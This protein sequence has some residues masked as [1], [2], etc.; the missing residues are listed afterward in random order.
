[1]SAQVALPSSSRGSGLGA[2]KDTNVSE[3]K[4]GKAPAIDPDASE[5][6]HVSEKKK[7]KAPAVD[8]DD[9][10]VELVVRSDD[11][12]HPQFQDE[13]EDSSETS[14]SDDSLADPNEDATLRQTKKKEKRRE[15]D[16]LYQDPVKKAEHRAATK[17]RR[18]QRDQ[19]D[20]AELLN[21][22]IKGY[23]EARKTKVPPP[24][25]PEKI[26]KI[27]RGL[28]PTVKSWWRE[29]DS[30]NMSVA[31]QTQFRQAERKVD[32]YINS[33]MK[34]PEQKAAYE[35]Y[36]ARWPKKE[37]SEK[38][39]LRQQNPQASEETIKNKLLHAEAKF[40][41]EIGVKDRK[42]MSN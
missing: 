38:Q 30:M 42:K 9:K 20:R 3:K 1:M 40:R 2:T 32:D 14:G 15:K 37:K 11:D 33:V 4:K 19:R 24:A 10:D 6:T 7:G 23:T 27:W 12:Y 16:L 29:S 22:G 25:R 35:R 8:P 17:A 36:L 39:A 28:Y 13:D 41:E 21:E 31:H 26:Q 5:D 18:R 34:S